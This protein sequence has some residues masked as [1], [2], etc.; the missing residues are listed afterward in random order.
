MEYNPAPIDNGDIAT[1]LR[2]YM[3]SGVDDSTG[4]ETIDHFSRPDM[5]Q[6]P[7]KISATISQPGHQART[8]PVLLPVE[9]IAREAQK[10]ADCC[11]TLTELKEVIS[12]FDGCLLKRTATH[13]VFADGNPDSHIMLIGDAPGDHEDREG[14]AF[15]GEVGELL[16]R[17]LGAIGLERAQDFY[18]TN[19]LPWRP[20]GNRK[21]TDEE[22]TVCLPFIKKHIELFNPELIILLGGISANNLLGSTAGIARLRGTWKDYDLKG[23]KI[24]VR[25][26]FH[27]VYLLKQPRAKGA[28]W[29]DLLEIK[30]KIGGLS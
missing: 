4:L 24:P 1:L 10:Q 26:L 7:Q 18:V 22:I 19:I 2:W 15:T 6:H 27:P 20:P 11:K 17:M 28:A 5:P 8:V 13:T 14:T 30:A 9:E 16:D 23:R 3:D 12:N 25:A 29:Q 21:P